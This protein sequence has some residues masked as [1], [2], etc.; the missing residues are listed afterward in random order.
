M[1]FARGF[2]NRRRS[3]RYQEKAVSAR[4]T[5]AELQGRRSAYRIKIESAASDGDSYNAAGR[6]RLSL[7]SAISPTRIARS[8]AMCCGKLQCS[9][10]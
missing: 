7:Q 4:M 8:I 2:S 9:L 6:A 1:F 5:T 3:N 10:A